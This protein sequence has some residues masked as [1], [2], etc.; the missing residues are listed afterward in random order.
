MLPIGS[1]HG[2]V[3]ALGTAQTL[4]WASSFYLPAMLAAPMARDTG[5]ATPTVYALLSVALLVS[6]LVGPSAGR[7]IDRHGGRP[8]LLGATA[9]FALGLAL[10]AGAQGPWTLG[11]AWLVLG[12]AMGA[13]L[14][15]A[16]FAAVVYLYGQGARKS[17]TGITLLAGFAST[18]GW[19]LTAWFELRF[20]WRGAC[21]A[22]ALLHLVVAGPLYAALPRRALP[23]DTS[24]A[25]AS[26]AD[27]GTREAVA[28]PAVPTASLASLESAASVA[29]VAPV[30]PVPPRGLAP[31]LATVFALLSIVST[32]IA[33]HLPAL[34][35]A[36]GATLA[37]A[38]ATAALVGPA[39]VAARLLEVSL[40][41]RMSPLVAARAAA[42]GHP[43]AA[44]VLLALGGAAMAPFAV[45]HGLGN[46]LITIVRGT[47][48]LALFGAAG[49]GARQGWLT[50]PA[51]VLGALSPWLFGIALDRLGVQ[52][53]WITAAFGA[54][55]FGGL[56]WLRLPRQR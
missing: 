13:G 52:A 16:A 1:R 21:A 49:Y 3:L 2:V 23:G 47:L 53:L 34:L 25:P 33:T 46:G 6:A 37:V 42:F 45:L 28:D 48:P 12:L 51:R 31:L 29:P 55:A 20:G 35:Q 39:Q 26:P 44:A 7:L 24:A 8:V 27:L 19:P 38:V 15:D 14:Y 41:R 36:A 10:A 32:S 30:P 9:M 18:V 11:A 4:A 5:V 17:I 40:P 56:L 50:L 22:W 54:A 43:L